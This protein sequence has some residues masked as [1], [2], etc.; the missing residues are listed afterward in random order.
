MKND[1]KDEATRAFE[2]SEV[3]QA[4]EAADEVTE[5]CKTWADDVDLSHVWESAYAAC[6]AHE[7]AV[8]ASIEW[9]AY[10]VADTTY[11][12]NKKALDDV[13]YRAD[14]E[15]AEEALKSSDVWKAWVDCH[16]RSH[17]ININKLGKD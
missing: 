10:E 3:W 17:T 7:E 16:R 4:Y 13:A 8:K 5:A 1:K 2:A 6:L 15:A 12:A 14:L 11:N 9:K